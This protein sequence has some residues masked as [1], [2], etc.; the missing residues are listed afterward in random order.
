LTFV[1]ELT[2]RSDTSFCVISIFDFP[3]VWQLV[4]SAASV[5]TTT[6]QLP[7]RVSTYIRR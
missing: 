7:L 1:H 5:K 3:G 6:Q 2:E 4:P